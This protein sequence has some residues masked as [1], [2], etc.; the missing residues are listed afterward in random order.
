M[1]YG[2]GAEARGIMEDL[3]AA[4]EQFAAIAGELGADNRANEV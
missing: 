3:R 1:S 2:D 4:L